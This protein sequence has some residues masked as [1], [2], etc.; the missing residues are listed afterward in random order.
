MLEASRAKVKPMRAACKACA[1]HTGSLRHQ[2]EQL[3]PITD[4]QVRVLKLTASKGHATLLAKLAYNERILA[5]PQAGKLWR[6]AALAI[7][8]DTQIAQVAM[9]VNEMTLIAEKKQRRK[10]SRKR[11]G[12]GRK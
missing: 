5:H 1:P 3:R 9:E 10:T 6:W 8:Q 2:R 7:K 11:N 4:G 12:D